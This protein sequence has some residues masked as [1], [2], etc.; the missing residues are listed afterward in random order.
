MPFGIDSTNKYFFPLSHYNF[1]GFNENVSNRAK[2][3]FFAHSLNYYSLE[4]ELSF[5]KM[6]RFFPNHLRAKSHVETFP[7]E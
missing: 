3:T 7:L 4:T 1:T 6:Y 2:K 5:I